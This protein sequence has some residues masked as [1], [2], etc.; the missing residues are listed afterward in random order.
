[1]IT[2][3][4]ARAKYFKF[5]TTKHKRSKTTY[6]AAKLKR[7]IKKTMPAWAQTNKSESL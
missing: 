3:K 1:M 2:E 6:S 5:K 4:G 7:A